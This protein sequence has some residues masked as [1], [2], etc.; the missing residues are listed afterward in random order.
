MA[1]LAVVEHRNQDATIYVG[2]LD[3][4]CTEDLLTE[5]FVQVGRIQSVYMPKDKLT[6]VHNGYGF[7]EFADVIDADYAIAVMNMIKLYGRPVRVSKSSLHTN[8]GDQPIKDIG[9]NLFI[10]NLDP[11]DVDDQLLYDTFSAFGTMAKPCRLVRDEVTKESKG[12]GFVWYD[13]FMASDTAIECMNG[14][15]LGNRIISVLYAFKKD[16]DG[17]T[18]TSE[19]H[20]SRTERMLAEAIQQS[21][22]QQQHSFNPKY[23]NAGGSYFTPN[24]RFATSAQVANPSSMN[25]S[26]LLPPLPPPPPPSSMASSSVFLPP[27]PP[28]PP[29]PPSMAPGIALMP[30]PPPPPPLPPIISQIIV[31]PPPPMQP[32]PTIPM[33]PPVPSL[34]PPPPP[35]QTIYQPIPPPPPPPPIGQ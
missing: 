5:L 18:L 10:G 8:Q 11:N 17:K 15:Y 23:P 14:Q 31:P 13:S 27:P 29:L 22:K 2:N 3:G 16:I 25:M 28:P 35:S 34:P 20:G 21:Q 32:Q 26:T 12:Y 4:S 9:A 33:P 19:R 1:S 30:P 6:G 7:V 24:T